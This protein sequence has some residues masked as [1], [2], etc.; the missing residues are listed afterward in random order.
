L[1][2]RKE[3]ELVPIHELLSDDEANKVLKELNITAE[4]LPKIFADDPQAKKLSAKP[5]QIIRIKRE[6]GKGYYYYRHVV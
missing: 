5:G 4:R 6:E 3:H 1:S 2:A